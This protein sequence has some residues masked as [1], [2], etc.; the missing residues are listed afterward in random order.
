[1]VLDINMLRQND[2]DG[3]GVATSETVCSEG[4]QGSRQENDMFDELLQFA[5]RQCALMPNY[6]EAEARWLMAV[7]M[8][9]RKGAPTH[10]I[11]EYSDRLIAIFEERQKAQQRPL[12]D[13]LADQFNVLMGKDA[14]ANIKKDE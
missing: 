12:T 1:M 13:K 9:L 11:N 6:E 10:L 7:G 2:R 8:L 5:L 14:S 4:Q 3:G